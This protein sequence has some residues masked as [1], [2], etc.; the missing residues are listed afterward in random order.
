MVA[1]KIVEKHFGPETN[2][3]RCSQK[4]T[5]DQIEFLATQPEMIGI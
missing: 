1:V 3:R 5:N 2:G 4:S